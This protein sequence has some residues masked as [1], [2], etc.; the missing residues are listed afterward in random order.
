MG[1]GEGV[2][3]ALSVGSGVEPTACAV[4][5]AL[6]AVVALAPVVG[7]AAEFDGDGT[8]LGETLGDGEGDDVGEGDVD[9]G[10]LAVA[11]W[12][13]LGLGLQLGAPCEDG[14]DEPDDAGAVPPLDDE[15]EGAV[16]EGPPPNVCPPPLCP[17]PVPWF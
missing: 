1:F 10:G 4:A 12:S 8:G 9:T 15:G 17:P 11:L 14:A 3:V 6:A 16:G 2:L 13:G 7:D 5:G